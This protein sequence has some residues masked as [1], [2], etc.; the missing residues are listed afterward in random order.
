MSW[1][2]SHVISRHYLPIS[3]QISPFA[4]PQPHLLASSSFPPVIS[5]LHDF[6]SPDPPAFSARIIKPAWF[7]IFK[8]I[9]NYNLQREIHS[10]HPSLISYWRPLTFKPAMTC[11][12]AL[13]FMPL[14]THHQ[15]YFS[16]ICMITFFPKWPA[17]LLSHLLAHLFTQAYS[18]EILGACGFN[19]D[20]VLWLII[21]IWLR[22]EWATKPAGM[23]LPLMNNLLMNFVSLSN[24]HTRLLIS[25][26]STPLVLSLFGSIH[27]LPL[28]LQYLR[29]LMR[30]MRRSPCPTP[31]LL[32]ATP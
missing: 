15:L 5:T 18:W 19:L 13:H 3:H 22:K 6:L 14:F 1:F 9:K 20:L 16:H 27:R 23:L 2:S 10:N 31:M 11:P 7:D 4:W 26:A 25:S 21:F 28:I 30:G 24:N 29:W 32:L 8:L 12:M 17:R